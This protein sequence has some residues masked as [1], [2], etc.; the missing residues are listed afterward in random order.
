MHITVASPEW[1]EA[2]HKVDA[3]R[4]V[5]E[6]KLFDVRKRIVRDKR[7]RSVVIEIVRDIHLVQKQ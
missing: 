1:L 6:H 5:V 4:F 2:R 3:K 7:K